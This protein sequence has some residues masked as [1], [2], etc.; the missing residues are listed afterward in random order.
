L[1]RDPDSTAPVGEAI[2]STTIRAG[3]KSRHGHMPTLLCVGDILLSEH[4]ARYPTRKRNPGP[5]PP[6][7]I[8]TPKGKMGNTTVL[9]PIDGSADE[10]DEEETRPMMKRSTYANDRNYS[11]DDS[12]FLLND[13]DL[14][15]DFLVLDNM[16]TK[17]KSRT[18]ADGK[19]RGNLI[20]GGPPQQDTRN[21]TEEEK[22][23]YKAIRKEYT[24]GL[25]MERL[26]LVVGD[27]LPA[28]NFTG[29]CH[30]V[31][32]TEVEVEAK[33]LEVGH[34]FPS[35]DKLMLHV[36]EEANLRGIEIHTTRSD[37][38]AVKCLVETSELTR[39]TPSYMDGG[40]LA[41]LVLVMTL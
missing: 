27:T 28:D 3:D 2:I 32:R 16:I 20:V 14:Q 37:T 19:R 4:E 36:A 6:T 30:P 5:N 10:Y 38:L 25:R 1:A 11:D 34:S 13:A 8:H 9:S 26:K 17:K 31:L 24:D 40:L 22:K 18:K 29:C 39:I 15:E 23:H 33:R 35:K 41:I 12:D 21:M 7:I